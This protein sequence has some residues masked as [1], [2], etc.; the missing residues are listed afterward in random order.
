MVLRGFSDA[1][2]MRLQQALAARR[3][4][5]LP[6]AE[7]YDQVFSA[8]GHDHDL[9]SWRMPFVVG[10][11]NFVVPPADRCARCRPSR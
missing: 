7:H 11:M 6:A 2:M 1:I 10:L 4:R 8:H 5:W 9:L 3:R